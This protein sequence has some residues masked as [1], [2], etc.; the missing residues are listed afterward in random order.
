MPSR[1]EGRESSSRR[2]RSRRHRSRR[3]DHHRHH[4]SRSRQRQKHSEKNFPSAVFNML[5]IVLL[6]TS[7]AEPKWIS[8]FGGG[9]TLY[10]HDKPLTH[11]GTYQF[12]YTGKFLSQ[13]NDYP[14]GVKSHTTY[15][16]GPNSN[17]GMLFHLLKHFIQIINRPCVQ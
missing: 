11:L 10:G 14:D 16:F 2:S 9:C 1:S 3:R 7:L 13:E 15:Q 6:C 4:R 12:F 17:D 8:L 5:A